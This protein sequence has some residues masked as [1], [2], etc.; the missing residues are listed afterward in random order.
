MSA[1]QKLARRVRQ[2]AFRE[3]N[4]EYYTEYMR[5]YYLNHKHP[6]A[7]CGELCA[8]KHERCTRCENQ[9]R[10]KNAIY[11]VTEA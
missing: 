1:Y 9:R 5:N 8:P 3:K 2:R 10:G 4:P 6:C 11:T 7:E